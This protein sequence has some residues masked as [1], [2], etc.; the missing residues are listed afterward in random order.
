MICSDCIHNPVCRTAG[1]ESADC[2]NFIGIDCVINSP[3]RIGSKIFAIIEKKKATKDETYKYI[4]SYYSTYS[5][6]E[7][8][9]KN[10]GK[11]IF[12]TLEDA[13]DALA[14]MDC[15]ID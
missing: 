9:I 6:I 1:T 14:K 3:C 12:L 4:Q 15:N 2:E 10:F 8:V 5:N 11:T 13:E 7:R